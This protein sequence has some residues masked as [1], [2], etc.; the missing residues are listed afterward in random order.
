MAVVWICYRRGVRLDV[1]Y[2]LAA[3]G[4]APPYQLILSASFP[5]ADAF[6][7]ALQHPDI[8]AVVEDITYSD[9]GGVPDIVVGEVLA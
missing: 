6:R 5:S 4:P 1:D 9:D 7:M 3:D 8:G 2:D